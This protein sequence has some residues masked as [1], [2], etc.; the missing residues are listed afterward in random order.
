LLN[1][2]GWKRFKRLA[3]QEKKAERMRR[4]NALAAKRQGPKFQFGIQVPRNEKEAEDLDAKYVASF[5][6]P[7]WREAEE[8]EVASLL[9][10]DSFE[11]KGKGG[12]MPPGYRMIKVF[13]VYAVKHD[14]RHKAR[15][16]AGGHMTPD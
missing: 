13:L 10:Y 9:D 14:L 3:Q 8:L 11:D 16:V 12:R 7:K 6:T 4:Q 5:G 15:L 1:L 2:D